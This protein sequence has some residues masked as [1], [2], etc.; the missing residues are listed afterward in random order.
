LIRN[1]LVRRCPEQRDEDGGAGWI[2]HRPDD[3]GQR[4]PLPVQQ[5]QHEAGKK[6]IG[7][8][9]DRFRHEGGPPTLEPLPGHHAVLDR[10]QAQQNDI[11]NQCFRRRGDDATVN[12]LWNND[13]PNKANRIQEREEKNDVA[14]NSINQCG[15]WLSPLPSVSIVTAQLLQRAAPETDNNGCPLRRQSK[16]AIGARVKSAHHRQ[17]EPNQ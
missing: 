5:D 7:A 15:R 17:F 9:F 14:K 10:E 16:P 6:H 13:M 3:T 4:P 8:S 2:A 12:R 11:D 1:V